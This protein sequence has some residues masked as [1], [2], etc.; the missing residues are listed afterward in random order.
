MNRAISALTLTVLLIAML[1]LPAAAGKV[2]FFAQKWSPLGLPVKSVVFYGNSTV[3]FDQDNVIWKWNFINNTQMTWTVDSAVNDIVIPKSNN[4]YIA[5][6]TGNGRV[7]TLYTSNLAWRGGLILKHLNDHMSHKIAVSANGRRIVAIASGDYWYS[8]LRGRIQKWHIHN[9]HPV[10]EG[11]DETER[12]EIR[13][14]VLSSTGETI[15]VAD[16]DGNIDQRNFKDGRI[17]GVYDPFLKNQRVTELAISGYLL[18]SAYSG[19]QI[20][21][22]NWGP[23]GWAKNLQSSKS[24]PV[25]CLEFS[26]D[27]KYL[28]AGYENGEIHIW[29]VSNGRLVDILADSPHVIHDISFSDDGRYI[30][31]GTGVS[32]QV[33]DRNPYLYI[34]RR[35]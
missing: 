2:W 8:K 14:I 16:G 5:Y 18:A 28:A 3:F 4:S 12:R 20:Y 17:V 19:N 13:D 34:W 10:Y 22:W 11:T 9:S 31:A 23:N 27:G 29:N 30:A 33:R 25:S 1:C 24:S 21:L 6:L 32:Y 7:G 15:L 26:K 35:Q